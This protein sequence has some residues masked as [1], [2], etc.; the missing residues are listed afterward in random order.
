MYHHAAQALVAGGEPWHARTF[1]LFYAAPPSTLVLYVPFVWLPD[2]LIRIGWIA[3]GLGSSIYAVR[4]LGLPMWWLLFPP[5][6]EG[7]AAGSNAPLVL[8]LLIRAATLGDA[9][10]VVARIYA[11]IPLL[12]LARWRSI[13]AAV[14]LLLV[15]APFLDYPT[16]LGQLG[17]VLGQGGGRANLSTPSVPWLIPVAVVCLVMLGRVRAAWL[18]VPVLWPATNLYYASIAL[19]AL[20]GAPLIALGLAVPVPGL[21]VAGMV[22]QLV[23]W[24]LEA[25][26]SPLRLP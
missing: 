6:V 13:G 12:L 15:T 17:F 16:F 25:R 23:L 8:A 3:V 18:F 10:A 21:V 7:V 2:M 22:A 26:T 4:R 20:V 5:I 9:V 14:V 19:P 11:L 1:G 24:R